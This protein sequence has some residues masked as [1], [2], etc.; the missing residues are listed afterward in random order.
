MLP[1]APMA[2]VVLG[3]VRVQLNGRHLPAFANAC[4][5]DGIVLWALRRTGPSEATARMTVPGFRHCRRAARITHTRVHVLERLGLPFQMN[6]ALGRPALVGGAL[7]ILIALRILSS[8]VWFVDVQGAQGRTLTQVVAAAAALGLRPGAPRAALDPARISARLPGIVPSVAWAALRLQGVRAVL[9]IAERSTAGT[10]G[11]GQPAGPVDL[12]AASDGI[13][14]HVTALRGRALVAPGQTVVRG[15]VL[16]AA[17]RPSASGAPVSAR[18]TVTALVWYHKTAE[19]GLRRAVTVATGREAV[20]RRLR[21]FGWVLRLGPHPPLPFSD[22]RLASRTWTLT[23]GGVRLPVEVETLAYQ[24][25]TRHWRQLAPAEAA[26]EGTA[27][28]E[29]ELRRLLPTGARAEQTTVAYRLLP[30][31]RMIVEVNLAAVEDIARARPVAS[32]G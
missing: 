16:I 3:H 23:L 32:G 21:L 22:Y 19:I 15:Q 13:V 24:E 20:R 17:G 29:A 4:A 14:Q 5:T 9:E 31:E 30:G 6:R 1:L 26:A 18:G 27:T 8:Y 12:V 25:V 7:A 28:A 10:G 2:A 11:A